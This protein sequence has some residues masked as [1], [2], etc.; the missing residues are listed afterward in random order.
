[1]VNAKTLKS[2]GASL[3]ILAVIV[4]ALQS[5][6]KRMAQVEREWELAQSR[7]LQHAS[8]P[9]AAPAPTFQPIYPQNRPTYKLECG[10]T[11]INPPLVQYVTLILP[12]CGE[13]SG[14]VNRPVG[15]TMF[16]FGPTAVVEIEKKYQDGT[17]ETTTFNPWTGN[18]HEY[19][20][21]TAERFRNLGQESI[22]IR[23]QLEP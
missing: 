18:A 3:I 4:V 6:A 19:R 12:P 5:F 14:W 11:D 2:L 8:S 23:L 9:A 15:A 13:K 10:G 20:Y 16:L 22:T 21:I 17:S 1:M 7:E